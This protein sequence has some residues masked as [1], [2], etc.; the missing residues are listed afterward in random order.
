MMTY[1]KLQSSSSKTFFKHFFVKKAISYFQNKNG[2]HYVFDLE[3]YINK[4][5]RLPIYKNINVP[6]LQYINFI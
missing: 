2:L 5:E 4:N 6:I 1:L 3:I